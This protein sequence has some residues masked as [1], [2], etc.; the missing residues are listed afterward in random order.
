[1]DFG[2]RE[3]DGN[4]RRGHHVSRSVAAGSVDVESGQPVRGRLRS[5][6]PAPSCA[7]FEAAGEAL[8]LVVE[9]EHFARVGVGAGGVETATPRDEGGGLLAA[10]F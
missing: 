2:K 1:M 9:G 5:A 6:S 7:V 3:H 4:L 10:L 8:Q